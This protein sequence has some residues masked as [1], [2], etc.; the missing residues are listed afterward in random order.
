MSQMTPR[1]I[2]HEL[3][4]H[5]IGQNDA[6]RAVAIALRNRWRRS[7]LESDL[8]NEVTPKNIL[9][10]GQTRLVTNGSKFSYRKVRNK[11]KKVYEAN[12]TVFNAL[13]KSN[14]DK[15]GKFFFERY[16]SAHAIMISFEGVPAIYFNSLFGTSNDLD[17]VRK[18]GIKRDINR[19]KWDL[20]ALIKKL[21]DEKSIEKI[22]Y[23]KLLDMI[24][25]RKKQ[26]AFHPNATQFTLQLED[27]LFGI[28]RQSIDRSQSIFCVSNL[29]KS[30]NKKHQLYEKKLL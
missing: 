4:K 20:D 23:K 9:M 3:N 30:R 24:S 21:D 12:I 27:H 1:E 8:R 15:L 10:I 11:S 16:V 19:F 2:V 13:Y 18:T 5:I 14:F 28:W 25:L 7:Q 29:T 22:V 6:K 17:S 26:I